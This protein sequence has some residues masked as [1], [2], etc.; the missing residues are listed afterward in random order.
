VREVVKDWS[1]GIYSPDF[2]DSPPI[3]INLDN[4]WQC[5]P[6]APRFRRGALAARD[7]LLG[8]DPTKASGSVAL[9]KTIQ[10]TACKHIFETGS[11]NDLQAHVSKHILRFL[12]TERDTSVIFDMTV[13]F[14][15]LRTLRKHEAMQVV[16]NLVQLMGNYQTSPS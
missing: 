16:K 8:K 4:A 3:A 1:N 15:A 11:P 14:K 5:F 6:E 9:M 13:T 10:S 12:E 2:W 7:E